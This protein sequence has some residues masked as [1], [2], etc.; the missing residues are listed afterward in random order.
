MK[1]EDYWL[2]RMLNPPTPLTRGGQ[3]R[4]PRHF[5]RWASVPVR[6]N[7]ELTHKL[8]KLAASAGTMLPMCV[9]GIYVALLARWYKRRDLVVGFATTGR[10]RA[11]VERTVGF[12]AST[13][14]LRVEVAD[15][16]SFLDVLRRVT[17]EHSI[18][19][20]HHDGGLLSV[21]IPA[22]SY[23]LGPSFNWSS[24]PTHSERDSQMHHPESDCKPDTLTLD[25]FHYETEAPEFDADGDLPIYGGQPWA[26][27]VGSSEL[28]EGII[29]YR[30]YQFSA[31]SMEAFSNAFRACAEELTL[32]PQN[33]VL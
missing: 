32:H 21:P 6:L 30:P 10:N 14:F 29:M 8:S 20:D 11:E 2:T 31:E 4:L 15:T 22:P 7:T 17:S 1:H 13:I 25:H 28:I 23:A 12:F 27:I 19:M 3:P 5:P 9:F 16:D 26:R 33:A 18:A 24:M